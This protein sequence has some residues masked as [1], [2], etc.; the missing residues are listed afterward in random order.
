MSEDILSEAEIATRYPD[1]FVLI[2]VL[3]FA[4]DW[5]VKRGIVRGHGDDKDALHQAARE[6]PE[7]RQIAVRYTGELPEGMIYLL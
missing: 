2:D 6:L 4:D 3:E 1:Q 7:P 5:S